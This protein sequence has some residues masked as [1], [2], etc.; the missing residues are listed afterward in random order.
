MI[1]LSY[2]VL[3]VSLRALS[4][5]LLNRVLDVPNFARGFQVFVNRVVLYLVAKEYAPEH[6]A[7]VSWE[8]GKLA[9][10]SQIRNGGEEQLQLPNLAL[11]F[12]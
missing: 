9:L 1:L 11:L 5:K 12:G 6:R 2:I 3:N 7:C 10:N 8:T 4:V